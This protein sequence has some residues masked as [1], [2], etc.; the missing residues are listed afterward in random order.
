M[1]C[2]FTEGRQ[3]LFAKRG[4]GS[5]ARHCLQSTDNA[6]VRPAQS[7]SVPESWHWSQKARHRPG[8][9]DTALGALGTA[10]EC[11]TPQR[12]GTTLQTFT[13]PVGAPHGSLG[14]QRCSQYLAICPLCLRIAVALWAFQGFSSLPFGALHSDLGSGASFAVHSAICCAGTREG[15]IVKLLCAGLTVRTSHGCIPLCLGDGTEPNAV[16]NSS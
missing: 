1:A 16:M 7:P 5:L 14:I 9:P 8:V 13:V 12:P 2:L 15:L 10:S 11:P 3:A 4:T 6:H